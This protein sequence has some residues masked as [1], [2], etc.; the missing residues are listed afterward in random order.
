MV[1]GLKKKMDRRLQTVLSQLK[2]R[3]IDCRSSL[4]WKL[5]TNVSQFRNATVTPLQH[6]HYYFLKTSKTHQ[7]FFSLFKSLCQ[8]YHTFEPLF[9]SISQIDKC[10]TVLIHLFIKHTD[11]SSGLH[12][13]GF[14]T[15]LW[16]VSLFFSTDILKFRMCHWF[17]YFLIQYMNVLSIWSIIDLE[18]LCHL[19]GFLKTWFSVSYWEATKTNK[20]NQNVRDFLTSQ[21]H[22]N[23]ILSIILRSSKKPQIPKP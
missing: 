18:T 5:V 23:P 15:R 13:F 1:G 10:I 8:I 19:Q 6:N 14:R 17:V 11:L 3:F 16:Y 4:F 7:V 22:Q 9:S 21:Y 20:S 2:V 12:T